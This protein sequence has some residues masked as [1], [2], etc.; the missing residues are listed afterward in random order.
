MG[1]IKMAYGNIVV[2]KTLRGQRRVPYMS[3]DELCSLRDA[4]IRST[5]MYAAKSVPFYREFFKKEKIDPREISSPE[6]LARLPLI[7]QEDVRADP[8]RFVSTS[9]RARNAILFHTTGSTGIPLDIYHDKRSLLENIAYGE[10]EREVVTKIMGRRFGYKEA[11]VLYSGAAMQKLNALCR[12]MTFIP[13]RPEKLWLSVYDPVEENIKALNDFKPDIIRSY[14]SYL[15]LLFREVASCG[16]NFRLP[17]LFVYGCDNLTD[18]VKEL[19]EGEYG[20]PVMSYYNSIESF[21]IAFSC[22][23][24]AGFHIHDDLCHLKV[25]NENDEMSTEGESGRVVI[26]NLVNRATVLLNYV[27]GDIGSLAKGPCPC[28]R[29]FSLLKRLEGRM[30]DIIHMPDGRFIHPR[31]IWSVFVGRREVLQYQFIQH[32]PGSFEL[33]V[34]TVDKESYARVIDDVISDIRANLGGQVKIEATYYDKIERSKGGK[35]RP[36][37]SLVKSRM[38]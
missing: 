1:L 25:I 11:P 35:F 8:M 4:R 14:G 23:E 3:K 5:V 37:I 2:A 16:R 7:T 29:T 22:E 6:E 32:L 18:E 9:R 26:S 28:G 27:L 38:A 20:I 13:V 15:D 19:I 33:K 17:K 10:R 34:V 24:S 12:E 30:D 36:V 31:L 21:R